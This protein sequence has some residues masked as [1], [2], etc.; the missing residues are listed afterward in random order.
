MEDSLEVR[1][2]LAVLATQLA[3]LASLT[4]LFINKHP[5]PI[6]LPHQC[7]LWREKVEGRKMVCKNTLPRTVL[8]KMVARYPTIFPKQSE[9]H[10]VTLS[11][12][13][14]AHFIPSLS[15]SIFPTS[16]TMNFP[17]VSP[18]TS[19]WILTYKGTYQYPKKISAAHDQLSKSAS[20][21]VSV[22]SC[23]N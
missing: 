5:K 14:E 15:K 7:C 6:V 22:Q 18:Y 10:M 3:K 11:A 8:Q 17:C 4:T 1:V 21:N 13:P 16:V 23:H 19:M 9:K 2:V 12:N 20:R